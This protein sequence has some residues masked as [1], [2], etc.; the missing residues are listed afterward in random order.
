MFLEWTPSRLGRLLTGSAPWRLVVESDRLVVIVGGQQ[1]PIASET[2]TNFEI[3]RGLLWSELVWS[4][5]SSARFGGLSNLRAPGLRRAVDDL[6]KRSRCQRFD[7]Y[8]AKLAR[9]LA[10][11][12][13]ALSS[14]DEKHRWLTYE[15]QQALLDGKP[16]LDIT[17]ATLKVLLDTPEVRAHLGDRHD[18]AER[19]LQRWASD[20]S[21]TWERRNSLHMQRELVECKAL[22]N[23][24]ESKPLTD[25]QAEAVV[26]FDNRVQVIASA[27]SGKTSTMIAKAIYAMHRGIVSHKSIVMLAYNK[28]AAAELQARANASLERLGKPSV[29]IAAMTFH[30]L[31][32]K[33][34][35]AATGSTPHVPAW[36]RKQ[37]LALAKLAEIVDDLKDKSPAFRTRWDIFRLVFGRHIPLSRKDR[38]FDTANSA[39]EGKLV[40]L[41]GEEVASQEECIIANWL[42][43]NG[44]EY[45]YEREYEHPTATSVHRQY[46]PDFYYPELDLYHE[47]FALDAE[48]LPPEQFKKYLEGVEWKRKIHKQKGT[49]LIETLSHQ[50]RTGE[51]FIHL[52]KELTARGVKLDPNPDR[53]I[54]F[55]GLEPIKHADL[56]GLI[57]TFINHY[58]S[59][60]YTERDLEARLAAMDS[61][62]FK[63]R[64][65]MFVNLLI[66]VVKK[67][68]E[69]LDAENG[70][71]FEDMINKAAGY[72]ESGHRSPYDLVM[73]DEYQD[74]SRAR[75]RLCKALVRQPHRY[76]FAV[77][78]DWQSINRF[79]GADISVMTGFK[80]WYGHGQV[81]RLET[82]FRCPQAICD[83][84]SRFVSKNPAQFKKKVNSVTAPVG[85]AF[86]AIQ[87]DHRN[88]VAQAVDQYVER[89]YQQICSGSVPLGR[90]GKVNVFV[91]G[92]YKLDAKYLQDDWQQR[93][94]DR[95]AFRFKTVHTSKGDEADYVILPGMV[96]R[97]FPN[98]KVD[99]PLFY[100]VM[101]QGDTHPSSE[102]RRLFY[103]AL[104]RAR[105]CVAM[106]TVA[107]RRS[108]FLQELIEEGAVS[109]CDANG[110]AITEPTLI[111][112][113]PHAAASG[114]A[115]IASNPGAPVCPGCKAGKLIGRTG[116]YGEFLSC[117]TYPKCDYKPPKKKSSKAST[118]KNGSK[119]VK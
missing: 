67:W 24:V 20:W 25:E 115:K 42:F 65:D 74:A 113:E 59:N 64:F 29:E 71:D 78:D 17:L 79:A 56:L 84:S 91:L 96:M 108:S 104:T 117:S 50:V 111:E 10:D 99:D 1:Y 14:A 72:L 98:V 12:D 101:P 28:D 45:Q 52:A 23:K 73:A 49:K 106:F 44:V 90:G 76:L 109:P 94:G 69:A 87:V 107:G 60:C 36:A 57:R 30:S 103:V 89:L 33:I 31:G 4:S 63:Y 2:L 82:T 40:T 116:P 26:C 48:G 19:D 39:G 54:P 15:N 86:Q 51:A 32:L 5:S 95:I 100:L 43:Y 110:Q 8:Y 46:F 13:Q 77:G 81:L 88:K 80:P 61:G 38:Q 21:Q 83:V 75:A 66:P 6:L 102:E 112:S 68:N 7:M 70:I 119:P 85:P 105:R 35:G 92:R 34:I 16:S 9:W 97:G 114:A 58:K 62:T 93:F 27:G 41:K 53:P 55:N 18:R 11:V 37:H 118:P 22:F 3:K 47:H